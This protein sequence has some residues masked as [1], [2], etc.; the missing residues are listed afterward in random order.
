MGL[1]LRLSLRNLL[2][3]KKRNLLLGL[4]IAFGMMVL[5]IASSFSHGMVDVLIEDIASMIYGQVVIDSQAGNS[6]YS[7]VRDKQRL[8]EIIRETI[9]P[10]DLVAI[11]EKLTM[12]VRA[13]GNGE[14]DNVVF[15]G[16]T[17]RTEKERQAFFTRF[18]TLV[19]GDF[20]EF[21]SAHY[22]YPVI[23]SQ[24]KAQSLNVKVHDEIRI[25]MPMITGQ[26]QAAKWTVIAIAKTNN[27]MLDM[28]V[29]M[30]GQRMKDLMGYKPWEAAALKISLKNPKKTAQ[31]YADLLHQ[32]LQPEIISIA[33]TIGQNPCQ[34]VA[35]K[36]NGSAKNLLKQTIRIIQGDQRESLEKDDI[37]LGCQ[38]ARQL[39]VEAGDEITFQYST[40][41]RGIY[42][43]KF[44]IT[45]IY[46]SIDPLG[47]N[48]LWVN[49]E[50]IHD[51]Y[52]R[53]LPAKQKADDI[54]KLEP[55][56]PL[57]ATEWKLLERS[58]DQDSLQKKYRDNRKI[59]TDQNKLDVVTMYEGAS[60][61]LRLEDVLNLVTVIAVLILFFIIL[62]GV[63]NT[64]RMTIRERTREIGT[65]RAVGMQKK[66]IRNMFLLESLL[67]TL[68]S[69]GAGLG[70]GIIAM[71]ILGTIQF[72]IS[73]ALSIILKNSHLHFKI[74]PLSLL[75]NF[76]LIMLISGVTA[77]FP[78]RSAARLTTVEALRHYE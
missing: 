66:D 16:V 50:R 52:N 77:Y 49:E 10:D 48:I 38:L 4:G 6:R 9:K 11:D 70:F 44:K 73:N 22:E 47:A 26:I 33:G 17:H 31:K 41:Y 51:L 67:L 29:F 69:C 42:N 53:Y 78:A 60:E 64:L 72:D 45:A 8:E 13:V 14:T 18:L 3:Q 46:D 24:E 40:K 54:A 58:A 37:L 56:A 30:D 12:V 23:I 55:V 68:F 7:I 61:V 25:R 75:S 71:Q 20:K 63:V 36:N 74:N 32:K 15:S 5:V 43:E 35:F 28:M 57:L 65:I 62:I 27:A 2:R 19:E 59:K 1:I 34:L 21:T 76:I 39:G